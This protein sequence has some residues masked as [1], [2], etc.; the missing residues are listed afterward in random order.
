VSM[1]LSALVV[2]L[3][4]SALASSARGLNLLAPH[5]ETK[6][7]RI[8]K[9]VAAEAF[10]E[11]GIIGGRRLGSLGLNFVQHFIGLVEGDV[12]EVSLKAWT[13]LYA[14]GDQALIEVLGGEERA[15]VPFL[16]YIYRLMEMG[17]SGPSHLDG[18]SNFA[19]M[20]SA[21]DH[22]LWAVHWSVNH[23]NEWTVGAVY[24][25]HPH[26]DWRIDSRLFGG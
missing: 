2:I 15:A 23:A 25:P 18:R 20:R 14:S 5:S 26:L 17:E 11:G 8:E 21:I 6:I 1:P 19:Y 9:F 13:L 7:D 22:R 24:V 16:A 10:K 4:I 12:P 3:L